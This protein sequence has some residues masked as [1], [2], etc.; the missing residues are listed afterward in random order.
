MKA[1][2]F[3]P[4]K[5]KTWHP[6]RFGPIINRSASDKLW[7]IYSS[8]TLLFPNHKKV[9]M[10]FHGSASD[11]TDRIWRADSQNYIYK[12]KL[13]FSQPSWS[14]KK[15]VIEKDVGTIGGDPSIIRNDKRWMMYF[16]SSQSPACHD[17]PKQNDRIQLVWSAKDD[18][19]WS[20][21]KP[22]L[23]PSKYSGPC[24][25]EEGVCTVQVKDDP[26]FGFMQRPSVVF[27]DGLY[28]LYFDKHGLP[29]S[30]ISKDKPL[31]HNGSG[32]YVATGKD[33]MN[34]N[35]KRTLKSPGVTAEV[36]RFANG[37]IM[38]FDREINRLQYK[39]SE[40]GLDFGDDVKIL[41]DPETTIT[42]V[43]IIRE[44]DRLLGVQY[45][46]FPQ[47]TPYWESGGKQ[48][49]F[50]KADACVKP[51]EFC[52]QPNG[53]F[54]WASSNY[55][56]R[57]KDAADQ[58]LVFP[59]I[60]RA[61]IATGSDGGRGNSF[62]GSVSFHNKAN[63]Q[64][65][66]T[67]EV[68]FKRVFYHD[69]NECEYVADPEKNFCIDKGN[70]KALFLQRHVEFHADD[71][72]VFKENFALDADRLELITNLPMDGTTS[73]TLRV[74]DSDGVTELHNQ[75]LQLRAGYLYEWKNY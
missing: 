68:G 69:N 28:Y 6:F 5:L 53:W 58:P 42:N 30:E 22:N 34:F 54:H 70:I 57:F 33:G 23:D 12:D 20:A 67:Y 41:D 19:S 61:I 37:W 9:V 36:E 62:Q 3:S 26:Y 11:R 27:H 38:F 46:A 16:S 17:C 64:I 8:E 43:N 39:L 59:S 32:I 35:L 10:F 50:Y 75:K 25:I 66:G 24:R 48:H 4:Q 51:Q 49:Y 14:E 7:N 40:N 65:I 60:E 2:A 47:G 29:L 72:R 15:V 73:G 44:G 13:D 71:G 1:E 56:L 21:N 55:E 52:S 74:Y 45:G 63:G 18:P 31:P